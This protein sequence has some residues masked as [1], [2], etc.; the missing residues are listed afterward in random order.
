MSVVIVGGILL[1]LLWKPLVAVL[2]WMVFKNI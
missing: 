1:A 2:A